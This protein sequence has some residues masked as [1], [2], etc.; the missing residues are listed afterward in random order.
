MFKQ[1]RDETIV[2]L[3]GTRGKGFKKELLAD[4][5]Y[6]TLISLCTTGTYDEL[7]YCIDHNDSPF[8]HRCPICGRLC[9]FNR[10]YFGSC[11]T[12]ECVCSILLRNN[13]IKDKHQYI[14]DNY[15]KGEKRFNY[16]QIG[17]IEKYHVFSNSQLKG[18]HESVVNAYANKTD[19]ERKARREKTIKTCREK[20]GTDFSQQNADIRKKQSKTWHSKSKEE[21][22]E[23][24]KR[25]KQTCIEKYGVDHVMKSQEIIEEVKQRHLKENG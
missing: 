7:K 25:R 10:E 14:I 2:N 24:T 4:K 8:N 9:G 12:N 13:D 19:E 11:R 5:N 23:T 3:I 6:N 17:F 20:Y 16:I 18:W 21:T 22:N 15:L 1:L